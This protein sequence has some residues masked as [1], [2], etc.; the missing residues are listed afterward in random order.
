MTNLPTTQAPRNGAGARHPSRTAGLGRASLAAAAVLVCAT[1]LAGCFPVIAGAM[2]TGVAMATDRRPAATQTVDRGLQLEAESTI[3]S[4]YSGQARVNV[5]V[6]NRKVLL[7]GEASN[8]NVKQQIEQYVRGLPN[9]RVVIN[10][11]EIVNSPGFM[12]QSQDAYLTSKVK[13]L[14]MTAEGVPSNSIKI[15]TEKSVVYLLGVVT[16]AEGDRATD[17]ARNASGVTK[18]VKA[19]DYVNDTERARLD[20]ASTSQNPSF[21]GN[22]GTPAP[23]QSV[24]GVGGPV[25]APAG[26][27]AG[28][29]AT[30]S[31][32]AAPVTS[33][34][35]LPPGRNL[36]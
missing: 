26:A 31:P 32:V 12:T 29:A 34:V 13:T 11:L 18:V 30:T 5:T 21:D 7:T 6:F 25:D 14:M 27:A 10:E 22:V 20:A 19:F 28:T 2:G 4:R 23:V 16:A 15:T 3:N 36:P 17:V 9:A 8:D 1:Q 24:P 35:T 33:P